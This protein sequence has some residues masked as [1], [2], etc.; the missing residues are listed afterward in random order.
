MADRRKKVMIFGLL[1]AVWYV[2]ADAYWV[3]KERDV[4]NCILQKS[5]LLI[6]NTLHQE[7]FLDI[8][9]SMSSAYFWAN[10]MVD[11]ECSSAEGLGSDWTSFSGLAY[12]EAIILV[13]VIHRVSFN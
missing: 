9:E 3:S 10:A 13:P 4:N 12:W 1:L 7:Y 2:I 11:D 6:S 8:R 5:T